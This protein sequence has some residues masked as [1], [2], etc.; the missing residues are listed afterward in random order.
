MN[1]TRSSPHDTTF[2]SF[3]HST[4]APSREHHAYDWSK[5]PYTAGGAFALFSPGQFSKLYP[6]LVRPAADSRL[7]IVGE[8]ASAHH[9]WIAGAL[10]SAARAVYLFLERFR[11]F[12][13][14]DKFVKE[15][16]PA[17]EV[18]EETAHLQVALGMLEGKWQPRSQIG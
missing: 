16:G 12:E 15:F 13:L 10:D 14:Q 9:A 17:G 4:N 8:A 7:H 3:Q 1:H 6:N 11:L 18:D 5:D 2:P